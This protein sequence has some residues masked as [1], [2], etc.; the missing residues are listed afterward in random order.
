MEKE[1]AAPID[2]CSNQAKHT[3]SLANTQA[4]PRW[5]MSIRDL[6]NTTAPARYKI[7]APDAEPRE[8]TLSK[9]KRQVLEALMMG[10]LYCATTVRIGDVVFRLKE[11]NG[12]LAQTLPLD[13]PDARKFYALADHVER[14]SDEVTA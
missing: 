1:T 8:V 5:I 7:T 2:D 14:V 12:P 4:K 13:D 6:P 3:N 11:T 9:R 10:L